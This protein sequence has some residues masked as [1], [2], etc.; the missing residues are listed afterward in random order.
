MGKVNLDVTIN[1]KVHEGL[2]LFVVDNNTMSASAML[3]RDILC[4]FN[5]KLI[6]DTVTMIDEVLEILNIDVTDE[7]DE[8]K[9][10]LDINTEIPNKIK[11]DLEK[12]FMTEYVKPERP[13]KPEIDF[14]VK[15]VLKEHQPCHYSA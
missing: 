9:C 15:L 4:K 8:G 14:E 1:N 12:L 13:V 2:R 11:S 5:F 10:E 3:G 6:N 7:E